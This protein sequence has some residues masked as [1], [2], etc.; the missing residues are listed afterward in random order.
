MARSGT[1]PTMN[2]PKAVRFQ[3]HRRRASVAAVL[4]G[5][6]A[7]LIA[8]LPP[9]STWILEPAIRLGAGMPGPFRDVVT[10]LVLVVGL[11]LVWEAAALPARL[12]FGRRIQGRY[13][14]DPAPAI[15]DILRAQA[16]T[17]VALV[18]VLGTG[19]L[20]VRLAVWAA[21]DW[22]WLVAGLALAGTLLAALH[23]APIVIGRLAGARPVQREGL[24]DRLAGLARRA[25]VQVRDFCDLPDGPGPALAALVTGLGRSRR[26]F[27][28]T[29]LIRDWTD[30]EIAVV[31]AHELGHHAHRDLWRAALLDAGVLSA[32]LFAAAT[33]VRA[34]GAMLGISGAGDAAALPVIALAVGLVWVMATPFRHAQSRRHERRADAFALALTGHVEA[35][36]TAIRRL[37][38]RHLA[39]ERPAALT[40]W[41]FH[42]HPPVAE[43]LEFARGYRSANGG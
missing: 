24:A 41:F 17:A 39:E 13:G 19:A 6:T 8:S 23:A 31:V 15:E 20:A 14:P 38:A 37:G 36:D 10:R 30:E 34:A 1:R 25:R 29:E 5:A 42:R 16:Q 3:R 28:S 33:I 22:W 9:A 35:F 11:V 43:R 40:R 4:S 12:H 2:E 7:L 26:V 32:G 21:G 18:P 27:L